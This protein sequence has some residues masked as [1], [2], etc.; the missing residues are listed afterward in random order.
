MQ[1]NGCLQEN[2]KIPSLVAI[3]CQIGRFNVSGKKACNDLWLLYGIPMY[4]K[5]TGF[6]D[7]FIPT[8]VNRSVV[9]TDKRTFSD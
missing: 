9:G 8:V 7:S 5:C 2:V 3:M 6:V 1:H 4:T